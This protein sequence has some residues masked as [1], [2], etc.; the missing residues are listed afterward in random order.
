[1]KRANCPREEATAQAART[2]AWSDELAAHAADCAV[3]GGVA[4]AARWMQA[5]ASADGGDEAPLP[6]PR[7]LWQRA[8]AFEDRAKVERVSATLEWAEIAAV[9]AVPVGLAGWIAWN[10][11]A[12][13]G[14]AARF[15]VDALP[16]LPAPAYGLASLAPAA[17][18]I[19]VLALGYPLMT[20]E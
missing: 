12:I 15:L 17:L 20:P 8:R 3:C 16:Q 18:V 5:F 14:A 7:L 11:F 1:M 9:A 2:N 13:E 10:W 6:D 19:G 4:R